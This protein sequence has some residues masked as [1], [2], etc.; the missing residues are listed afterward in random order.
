[1]D[2]I[3]E[4]LISGGYTYADHTDG[5]ATYRRGGSIIEITDPYRDISYQIEYF[6]TEIDSIIRLD[7]G[8]GDRRF[9][10]KITLPLVTYRQEITRLD[11]VLNIPLLD[12][13]DSSEIPQKQE[14][15]IV[16][17]ILI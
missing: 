9:L 12:Q 6:D 11:G 2:H 5:R 10:A 16:P 8:T 4:L 1:M 3:I 7:R 14:S 17:I 13:I 15:R